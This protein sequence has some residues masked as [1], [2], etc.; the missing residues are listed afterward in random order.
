ML[1]VYFTEQNNY[2][3]WYSRWKESFCTDVKSCIGEIF[4]F[5]L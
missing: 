1:S 5:S 4:T 2:V 3:I